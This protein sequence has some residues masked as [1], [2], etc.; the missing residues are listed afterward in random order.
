[1]KRLVLGVVCF[2]LLFPPHFAAQRGGGGFG[3]R[4]SGGGGAFHGGA[5][6]GSG[7]QGNGGLR[8]GF[9]G[10][11]PLRP[12]L[13]PVRKFNQ[14]RKHGNGGAGTGFFP[15]AYGYLDAGYYDNGNQGPVIVLEQPESPT[16]ALPPPPPPP[17]PPQPELHAYSWPESS[18]D[19]S[20]LFTI[21]SR[22][23]AVSSAVAV[24][25]QNNT[26]CYF[27]PD[28]SAGSMELNSINREATRTVNAA[29]SLRLS[30]PAESSRRR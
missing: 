8:G 2:G 14:I 29:K 18:N 21:I 13:G 6:L 12:P 1:M 11:P 24:W 23:G 9:I 20:A 26:V 25:V 16:M 22:D 5:P 19:P 7:F 27:A 28:G 17:P 10:L 3:G 4:G 30:L 15:F